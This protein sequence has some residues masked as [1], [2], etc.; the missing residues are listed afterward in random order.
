MKLGRLAELAKA[1][2]RPGQGLNKALL[3]LREISVGHEDIV[4]YIWS[5]PFRSLTA[6]GRN[7]F[8]PE[9]A[10]LLVFAKQVFA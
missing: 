2:H 5:E 4:L 9:V 7:I 8:R 1:P 10:P 3:D 6:R